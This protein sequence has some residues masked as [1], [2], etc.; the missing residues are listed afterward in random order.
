MNYG[1]EIAYWYLRLNGLF[2]IQNFVLHRHHGFH[3]PAQVDLLGV[4]PP[5]VRER[6][7]AEDLDMDTQLFDLI[8]GVKRWLGVICEVKTG[9]RVNDPFDTARLPGLI[10][11]LG[12][13][14]EEDQEQ[15]FRQLSEVPHAAVG[16]VMVA[17]IVISVNEIHSPLFHT[18][19]LD[20]AERF[21]QQ[22]AARFARVKHEDRMLFPWGVFQ[23]A[24][25]RAR[26]GADL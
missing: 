7:D 23:Y 3:G 25:N 18:I 19:S 20:D 10:A 1:E 15:L 13:L 14:S 8:G 22:R 17:K 4:R 16:A 2:L 5:F 24:I 21:I 6:I 12:L 26:E 11:R 9:R